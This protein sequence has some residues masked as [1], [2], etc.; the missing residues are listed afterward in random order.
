MSHTS[1]DREN[2]VPREAMI[3]ALENLQTAH[4]SLACPD[5]AEDAWDFV[6]EHLSA[7]GYRIVPLEPTPAMWAAVNAVERGHVSKLC[8]AEG[9]RAMLEEAGR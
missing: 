4:V 6:V 2:Q 3:A 5:C 7:M 9:W 1:A 8:S